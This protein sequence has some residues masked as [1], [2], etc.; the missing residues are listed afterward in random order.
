MLFCEE[1]HGFI[2]GK[3]CDWSERIGGT[4]DVLEDDERLTTS[5]ECL[6]CDDVEDLAELREDS[7]QRLLQLWKHIF[8]YLGTRS[9]YLRSECPHWGISRD[10]PI[11]KSEYSN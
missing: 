10:N 8:I 11:S 2:V 3:P 6:H 7:V 1:Y 9:K 4:V 5:L